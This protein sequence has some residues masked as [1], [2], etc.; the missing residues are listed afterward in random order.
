LLET[1]FFMDLPHTSFISFAAALGIG[2]LAGLERERKKGTGQDRR[3]AGLRTFA[4][5]AMLG[6]VTMM[7]GGAPLLIGALLGLSFLLAVAYW[8]SQQEDP[9]LTTEV[10]LLLV[11]VLGALAVSTPTLATSLGVVLTLLLAYREDLH[12]FAL[13]QLSEHEV[14]DG[15]T[16]ATAALVILPL[17]P[18]QYMGPYNAVNPRTI[19][20]LSVLMIKRQLAERS[21]CGWR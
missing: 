20:L 17:V 14:R 1:D 4:I 3:P 7:L 5:T 19:W 18:N 9:G 15:L 2:L 16:L 10:S 13:T 21:I 12:H 11:L 6:H 8:R